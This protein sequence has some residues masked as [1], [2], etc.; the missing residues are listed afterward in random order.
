MKIEQLEYLIKII[1]SGSMNQAAEELYIARSSLST[2]MKRLE[3][4]LGEQIFLRHSNGVSL[5]PFGASV[6]LQAQEICSRV[7]FLRN[8]SSVRPQNHLHVASMFCSMA[9]DAFARFLLKHQGDRLEAS[10]EEVSA[11]TAIQMVEN[12]ICEIGIL[13]LFSNTEEMTLRRLSNSGIEFHRAASRQVGAIV[14]RKNPLYHSDVEEIGLQEVLLYPH[15]ENYATPTD[16]AW[17]HR[18]LPKN[19][20]QGRYVVSDLGLALR[21]ISETDAV[22]IDARDDK[23]Y[24]SFYASSDYRFIPIRDYPAC[25]TGWITLRTNALTPLLQEFI[26]IFSAEAALAT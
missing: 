2:S 11:N 13:T 10:I 1:E 21:L 9:N 15:L 19:G 23:I 22:M 7:Q 24:Q 3:E 6:Y 20:F 5:T 26:D 4:E 8:A 12:G 14:G 25:T 17:E 16:H 18:F